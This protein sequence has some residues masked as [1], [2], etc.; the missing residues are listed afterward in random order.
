MST[1]YLGFVGVDQYLAL[2][3]EAQTF[4]MKPLIP[5]GG[6]C[7]LYGAPKLGKSYLGIQLAL[8]I[9]GQTPDF[10]GF[11]VTRPG[12]VL[13]L[14]LDT[15]R[16]VWAQRF[17]DMISKGNLKYDSNT[18][19]LGDRET[20][21]HF[22]FDI[23]Q[24]AHMKELNL[25]CQINQPVAVV[26]DTLRELH[27]GDE[28]NSTTARNVI[29]N[30]VGATSPAALILISHDRKPNPDREQDIMAD[31]RG[32]SYITGRMDA[33]IRLSKNKLRYAGRSIEE[34]D[35]KVERMDN[36]LWREAPDEY[37]PIIMKVMADPTLHSWSARARVLAPL[38]HKSE[39]AA[40]SLLRRR[41][42][43]KPLPLQTN[44]MRPTVGAEIDISN[45]G[46]VIE[47]T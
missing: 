46:E 4:L 17:Q 18:L 15:P 38:I 11:P 3:R 21:E 20:F 37:L 26:V 6:A 23:L 36:G 34:G 16:S 42:S 22:P 45:F 28:D 39:D 7:L 31:H 14:Q 29:A 24:P 5:M 2:P 44:L 12:K 13:Y 9:S 19:L 35:I 1:Q 8:A 25:Y 33:I 40:K 30:L 41:F 43:E 47:G 27:S 32:S 10:M